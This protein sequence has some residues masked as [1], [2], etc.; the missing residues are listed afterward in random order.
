MIFD[1]KKIITWTDLV[2]V[3]NNHCINI[4]EKPSGKK[5]RNVVRDINIEYKKITIQ[6]IKNFWKSSK[7]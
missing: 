4:A 2:E 5:P 7:Y 1:G 3:F 6:V